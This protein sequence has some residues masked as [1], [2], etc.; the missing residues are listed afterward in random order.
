MKSHALLAIMLSLSPILSCHAAVSGMTLD[1]NGQP[2]TGC[3]VLLGGN[4]A[5][6]ASGGTFTV[7]PGNESSADTLQINCPGYAPKFIGL[8]NG[9][10]DLGEITLKRP[11]FILLLSDDQG[12]VQTS[13]QMD[14]D[15]PTT[16]SDYFKT[17][18]IDSFFQSGM[19]FVRGYSPGTYCMPTRRSI[20][21][22]MSPLRH[23][24]NGQ[25]VPQW[26]SAYKALPSIPRVL[27][28]ADPDYRAAHF[29]KWDLR[30]DD[31]D[32]AELGYDASDGATGNGEGNV[33]AQVD[34]KLD[35]FTARPSEDPK[36]IFDLTDRG[37]AFMEE[38]VKAGR[39]FYLQLSHYA[40]HLSVFFRQD[41]YDEVKGWPTG[42]KHYIPSFAAMLKDMDEGFG[43]LFEKV[44]ELG[45]EDHTYIIYMADNGGRPTLNLSDG[46]SR[47]HRNAP[48]S[49][50]KHSIYEGG[51]R[52][53]FGIAGPGIEPGS[54]TRTAVSGMDI[55]PTL[56]DL[57][58]ANV[59]LGEIDGGSFKSLVFQQ[60]DSVERPNPY[61]LFHDK[62]GNPKSSEKSADSETAVMQGEYKLIKTWRNGK[63]H[64]AELYDLASDP[65]EGNNLAESM[66]E[67]T[68]RMG[69]LIDDYIAR[70]QGDVTIDHDDWPPKKGKQ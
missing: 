19:R 30:F 29:G 47:E 69:Q 36:N 14:P 64:T 5:L 3:N 27:K 11:N 44:R 50:G 68:A 16:R 6:S 21:V 35:K 62:S 2:L 9:A 20:Q 66:P 40:L 4:Q 38:Q 48:L 53:P 70:W 13:T 1:D 8:E 49:V 28:A 56:A 60:S 63:Q 57:A 10:S 61:L 59:E 52:V 43:Q 12:W 58:G 25:P 67:R 31:P 45:I 42:E 23:A 54:F 32:P 65:G 39:P 18:N 34:G 51:I 24:F 17:P 33:G 15:D 46:R 37:A 7:E 41:S 55:L 26:T 22:A